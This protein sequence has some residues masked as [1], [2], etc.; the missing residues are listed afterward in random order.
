ME[1]IV[2]PNALSWIWILWLAGCF[3][4]SKVTGWS[5]LGVRYRFR[6]R[7]RG[8][9][10]PMQ[11]VRMRWMMNYSNCV[12][13]GANE[14]GLYVAM[15]VLFRP[16]HP[17]LLIPWA[18][19]TVSTETDP[20]GLQ[21]VVF[22]PKGAPN[23]TLAVSARVA[24]ELCAQAPGKRTKT[25]PPPDEPE[26]ESRRA[27]SSVPTSPR[28]SSQPSEPSLE[29]PTETLEETER[30]RKAEMK[31]HLDRILDATKH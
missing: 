14:S 7:F 5:E 28:T 19:L 2:E 8:R 27:E 30:R 22:Q 11:S 24:G 1:Q 15:L 29:Q 13:L 26:E 9:R 17:T 25:A 16:F 6:G 21:F 18:E 3:L 4:F 20:F 10:F 23:I 12:T 31:A